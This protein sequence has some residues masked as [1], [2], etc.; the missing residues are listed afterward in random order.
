MSRIQKAFERLPLGYYVQ[1]SRFVAEETEQ[2]I[3]S[4]CLFQKA[5]E[6]GWQ[7]RAEYF[8]QTWDNSKEP[9]PE[10]WMHDDACRSGITW[11]P[12]EPKWKELL[13]HWLENAEIKE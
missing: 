7:T 3:M 13:C 2:E 1:I 8:D 5:P 11:E 10:M 9:C 6:K 12:G 4:A